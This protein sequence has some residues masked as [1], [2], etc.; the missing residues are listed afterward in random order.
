MLQDRVSEHARL[1]W[2]RGPL[3][4]VLSW[5]TGLSYCLTMLCSTSWC[6]TSRHCTILPLTSLSRP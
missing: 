4:D 6:S 3:A 5:V 1:P 2:E